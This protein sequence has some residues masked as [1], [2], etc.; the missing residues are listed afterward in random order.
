MQRIDVCKKLCSS[1]RFQITMSASG[2]L[3]I[4]FLRFLPNRPFNSKCVYL[5]ILFFLLLLALTSAVV[6][7]SLSKKENLLFMAPHPNGVHCLACRVTRS[8]R[9]TSLLVFYSESKQAWMDNMHQQITDEVF[10]KRKKRNLSPLFVFVCFMV[11]LFSE[12]AHQHEQH[13]PLIWKRC[14]LKG[15]FFF[16]SPH[17]AEREDRHKIPQWKN[18]AMLEQ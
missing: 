18:A 11:D 16:F 1:R 4:I 8:A 13:L 15:L 7:S 9:L 5:F 17:S 2:V 10:I 3:N 14:D 6:F 12:A